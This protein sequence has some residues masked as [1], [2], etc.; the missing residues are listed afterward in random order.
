MT[1]EVEPVAATAL[2][3]EGTIIFPKSEWTE[4]RLAGF[5]VSRDE[6]CPAIIRMGFCNK[7]ICATDGMAVYLLH[8]S[9]SANCHWSC[10]LNVLLGERLENPDLGFVMTAGA[11]P[12]DLAGFYQSVPRVPP[13][14]PHYQIWRKVGEIAI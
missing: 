3:V 6:L 4:V 11:Y 8:L 7:G 2:S 9:I 13:E 14:Q 5:R 1:L 12:R 10:P